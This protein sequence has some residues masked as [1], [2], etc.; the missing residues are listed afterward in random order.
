MMEQIKNGVPLKK[1][2]DRHLNERQADKG[3]VAWDGVL[4]EIKKQKPLRK[5]PTNQPVTKQ[6]VDATPHARLMDEIKAGVTLKKTLT[7]TDARRV[8]TAQDEPANKASE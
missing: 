4:E 6:N 8:G 5:T 7:G 1:A 3:G 2:A